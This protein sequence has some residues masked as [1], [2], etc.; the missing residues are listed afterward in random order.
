M[1]TLATLSYLCGM[2]KFFW[3]IRIIGA[4]ALLIF[5]AAMLLAMLGVDIGLVR[6]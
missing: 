1:A 6:R 2:Q 4:I 5:A 3:T